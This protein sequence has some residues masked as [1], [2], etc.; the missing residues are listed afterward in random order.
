MLLYSNIKI[1]PDLNQ[2]VI[3]MTIMNYIFV[4]GL[5][6][7]TEHKNDM[8]GFFNIY[9]I[10]SHIKKILITKIFSIS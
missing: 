9:I 8:H 10:I 3:F 6:K 2:D 1:N 4:I 5:L 7:F